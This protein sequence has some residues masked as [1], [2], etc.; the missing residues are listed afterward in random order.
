MRER[1]A[2]V[3]VS[4]EPC[5]VSAISTAGVES[6]LSFCLK[7][8]TRLEYRHH[9]QSGDGLSQGL[10]GI[11]DGFASV[12]LQQRQVAPR[13]TQTRSSLSDDRAHRPCAYYING[14]EGR[15]AEPGR[16]HGARDGRQQR[17]RAEQH[18]SHAPAPANPSSGRAG[19]RRRRN[20]RDLGK[21]HR[22]NRHPTDVCAASGLLP[23]SRGRARYWDTGTGSREVVGAVMRVGRRPRC[24]VGDG[25]SRGPGT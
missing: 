19:G 1:F 11:A 21:R 5:G 6:L 8:Q 12:Q 15:I 2:W 10:V 22:H 23:R 18:T 3:A 20:R 24:G 25:R 4:V 7:C 14:S 13:A 17:H 9:G 16:A